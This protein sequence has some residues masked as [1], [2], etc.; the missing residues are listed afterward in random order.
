MEM[1]MLPTEGGVH[2]AHLLGLASNESRTPKEDL[3]TRPTT[4]V[5]LDPSPAVATTTAETR[6]SFQSASEAGHEHHH[7]RQPGHCCSD[8]QRSSRDFVLKFLGDAAL[9]GPEDDIERGPPNF[10]RVM[11]RIDGLKCGCCE[12]GLSRAL[13]QTAAIRNHRVNT[14]L[15]RVEFDLDTN[16]LGVDNVVKLLSMRTGYSFEEYIVSVGQVLDFIITD[17]RLLKHASH[18]GGVLRVEAPERAPWRPLKR[19]TFFNKPAENQE[20]PATVRIPPTRIHYDATLIGARDV[21]EYYQKFDPDLRLA[22][23]VTDPGLELGAK[24]ARSSSILFVPTLAL[25]IPVVVFAWTPIDHSES[26]YAHVS[27][28]LAS[29]VQLIAINEFVPVAVRALYHAHVFE[30]DFLIFFSTTMAYIFS[31]V[32][33]VFQILDRPLETGSFFETSSLLV[34][35]ILLGRVINEFARYRAAKSVSFRSLQVEQALLVSPSTESWANTATSKIDSRLLQYGDVFTV[36]P[37]TRVVTDGIVLY[38]GSNIDESMITGEFKPKAKG[39]ESEVFAGTNNQDGSLVVKLTRLPHENSIHQIAAMVENAEL[40]KPKAQALAD[41]V[42]AWFVPA[43]A[44]IGFTVFFVWL[45]VNKYYN[46]HSWKSAALTAVTYAIATLAVSCPCAIGLAVPMVVLIASGVAARYG[47]IFRDPQMLEIARNVTDVVFDKTGTL[48]CGKLDVVGVP[49]YRNTDKARVKGLMMGLLKDINHPVSTGIVHHLAQDRIANKDFE[50]LEVKDI[51]SYPG[52]GVQ[53]KCAKTGAVIRAGNA[54]WLRINVIGKETNTRCYF[55]LADD[56][57]ATFE[58]KDRSRPG[59][60]VVIGKL[61]A[62]GIQVHM[63]SGDTEGAVEDTAGELHI[64]KEKTKSRCKPEGKCTYVRDL[65]TPGKVVMFVGDGTNDSVAL[66][67]ASIGVHINQGSSDVAKSAADVVLMTTRLHDIL[68]LLD[69]SK[70]AYRRI[71]ANFSW[72]AAYNLFAILLASGAF[73]KAG[74]QIRVQ[75]QWAGLGELVSVL[76][77]VLIA[78]Q[79]HCRNYGRKYRLIENDYQKVEAPRRARRIRTRGSSSMDSAGCC[80]I[81]STTLAKIDALTR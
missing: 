33:Y 26:I 79:M 68:I 40:T 6:P 54:E 5:H 69:I 42:A 67:Q 47:I 48:T 71:V 24:Q 56:L 75:P 7:H 55:T 25:T 45:I 19:L 2:R 23:V 73:V 66:K 11:L 14:I 44:M 49:R 70:A 65:Q 81:S 1:S 41:R 34:T 77:V 21:F 46:D 36:P 58:L 20:G 52:K 13:D 18:P 17:P 80:E 59:A 4:A 28:A 16:R 62:R 50:P 32:S 9:Q 27:C 29:V 57:R 31:V 74:S 35:L 60:E 37:H 39:L 22:P 64:Q 10:E 38:G 53:G 78:F 51:V 72:S 43:I 3:E 15:A 61:Q 12:G 76:P 63:I 8:S 30:M